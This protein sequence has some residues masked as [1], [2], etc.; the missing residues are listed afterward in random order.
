MKAISKTVKEY[1]LNSTQQS[2]KKAIF[3]CSNGGHLLQ[4][5]QA[6]KY[7]SDYE[8]YWVCIKKA[9]SESLLKNKNVF[10]AFHP[11]NR[12]YYNLVKNLFLA[13]KIFR[14]IHPSKIISTGAGV[15]IPFFLL[16]KIFPKTKTCYIESFARFTTPSLSGKVCYHLSDQFLFQWPELEKFYPK[17]TYAGSLY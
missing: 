5:L 4:L 3:V 7:A 16:A 6:E 1:F 2:K 10:W 15:A 13:I 12:N 17:G 9:D 8:I 11:T 14:Q